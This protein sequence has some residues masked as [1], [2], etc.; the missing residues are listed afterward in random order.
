MVLYFSVLNR[1]ITKDLIEY[2]WPSNI[3]ENMILHFSKLDKEITKDLIKK[4]NR[5]K[6]TENMIFKFLNIDIDIFIH[7]FR[8]NNTSTKNLINHLISIKNYNLIEDLID[9]FDRKYLT[10]SMVSHFIKNDLE[11]LTKKFLEKMDKEKITATLARDIMF[12]GYDKKYKLMLINYILIENITIE[13]LFDLISEKN[14]NLL[15]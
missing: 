14:M 12:S 7:C 4:I 5:E 9:Y 6:I 3:T 11:N 1:E 15:H 8:Q 2:I 13:F 10:F